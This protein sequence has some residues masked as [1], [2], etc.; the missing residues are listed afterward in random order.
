MGL[1][2]RLFSLDA[3]FPLI[4]AGATAAVNKPNAATTPLAAAALF[5][6]VKCLFMVL[7]ENVSLRYRV[8]KSYNMF[9]YGVKHF[10]TTELMCCIGT[11]FLKFIRFAKILENIFLGAKKSF[12]FLP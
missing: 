5:V 10:L 8:L 11:H 3:G 12:A 1:I 2:Q 4:S 9:C 6:N 7:V